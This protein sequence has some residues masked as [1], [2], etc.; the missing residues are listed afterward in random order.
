MYNFNLS[1]IRYDNLLSRVYNVYRIHA[2]YD[3]PFYGFFKSL[4]E[5]DSRKGTVPKTKCFYGR[6][7]VIVISHV[8][9]TTVQKMCTDRLVKIMDGYLHPWK[10]KTEQKSP[11][12]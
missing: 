3:N 12:A 4:S 7:G 5:A 8:L 11:K 6:C 9:C 10:F 1:C 2:L